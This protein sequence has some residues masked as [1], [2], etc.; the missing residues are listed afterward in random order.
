MRSCLAAGLGA[1]LLLGGCATRTAGAALSGPGSSAAQTSAGPAGRAGPAPG[2]ASPPAG[3]SCLG[4]ATPAIVRCLS[5]SLSRFWT[6]ELDRPVILHILVQPSSSRVPRDCRVALRLNTAFSCPTDD[7]VYLTA[8]FLARMRSTG[9]AGR[10]WLGIAS[11][12]G[13]EMGHIVQ[14]T[15]HEPLVSRARPTWAQSRRIEQQADCLDGVWSAEAGIDDAAFAAA[16][17][18]V[19]T[20]VDSRRGTALARH[21]GS[22]AGGVAPRAARAH[23]GRVWASADPALTW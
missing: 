16:T 20:I 14:F 6:A 5:A 17:R 10:S 4:P 8:R 11:T 18:I 13:H 12:M 2:S 1:L 21:T 3:L 7:T 22:A 23:A 15:V 19:L 9:P